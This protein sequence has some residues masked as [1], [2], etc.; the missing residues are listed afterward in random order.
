MNLPAHIVQ[1]SETWYKN[2]S[3]GKFIHRDNIESY[4]QQAVVVKTIKKAVKSASIKY[5]RNI[6]AA[7]RRWESD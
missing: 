5:K 4:C 3:N 7:F 2:T 6:K 1:V